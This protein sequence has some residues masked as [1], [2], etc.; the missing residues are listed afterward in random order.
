LKRPRRQH[1][2]GRVALEDLAAERKLRA[3]RGELEV[4]VVQ[5]E[6]PGGAQIK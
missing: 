6:T 2:G 3:M 1:S 5:P 4:P